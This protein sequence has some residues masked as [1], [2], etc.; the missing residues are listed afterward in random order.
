MCPFFEQKWRDVVTAECLSPLRFSPT[1][2]TS[3]QKGLTENGPK[4][5]STS[6]RSRW[7]PCGTRCPGDR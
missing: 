2:M 1:R 5:G 4:L 6:W 7:P 3:R